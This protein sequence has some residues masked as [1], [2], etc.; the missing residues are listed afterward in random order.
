MAAEKLPEADPQGLQ[1]VDAMLDDP[2]GYLRRER[3]A[4]LRAA[5]VYVDREIS[6]RLT[7]QQNDRPSLMQRIARWLGVGNAAAPPATG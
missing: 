7:E 6:R 2:I 1:Q 3:E 5:R 4:S